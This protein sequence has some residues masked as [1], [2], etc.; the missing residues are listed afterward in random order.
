MISDGVRTP[1][2][3]WR[4]VREILHKNDRRKIKLLITCTLV[5]GQSGIMRALFVPQMDK[6]TLNQEHRNIRG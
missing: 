1:T 3:H 6:N 5:C 4:T 2:L